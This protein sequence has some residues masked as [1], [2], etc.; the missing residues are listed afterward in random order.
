MSNVKAGDRAV[1]IRPSPYNPATLG[2]IVVVKYAAPRGR[3]FALPNKQ[4]HV[5]LR[6]DRLHWI[7]KASRRLSTPQICERDGTLVGSRMS[8]YLV[9]PDAY[10]RPLRDSDGEDEMTRI[11]GK[12]TEEQDRLWAE[13]DTAMSELEKRLA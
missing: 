3:G 12:P 5:T 1:C 4:Y 8:S 13:F 10:L 9:L 2:L 7:C 11:A 6:A